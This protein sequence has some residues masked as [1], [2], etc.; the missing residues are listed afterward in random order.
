MSGAAGAMRKVAEI[1]EL[2]EARGKRVGIGEEKILLVRDGGAVRAYAA[3]CPHAGAPLDEGAVCGGRIV[4]PWHKGA[5]RVSDGALLEP[6]ALDGLSRYPVRVDESGAVLVSPGKIPPER[7]R[8]APDARAMVVVGAGAAGA[9]AA[10]ALR[11]F[12]FGG[13]VVLVGREPG[14]PYDR[15]SLSKFVVS[16]EMAPGEVPP[17]LPPGFF[18]ERRIERIEAEAVRLDAP[19]RR[20]HLNDGRALPYDAALIATGGVPKRLGVPGADLPGVF[21]L[22]D[23]PDAAA[24]LAAAPEGARAVVLGAGFI[25]LEAAS[26]LRKRKV[27]V[28][29]VSPETAPFGKQFGPRLGAVFKGL[30]EAN[31][32]AFRPGAQASRLE[33]ADRVEAVVLEDGTR[34]QADLVLAGVGV[35]PATGFVQGLALAEDGGIPVDAGMRAADGLYA[36]GDVALFPLPGGGKPTRIEHWRVAQQHARVAARNMLGGGGR[37]DG[38]PYFWTYHFGKRFDYL[39]HATEWDDVVVEGDTA[40]HAFVAFLVKEG[41]V[42]GVL[43]CQRERETAALSEGMRAPLP[44]DEAL[45]TVRAA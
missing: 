39:G 23:R 37:Y 3:T 40:E 18:E 27:D 38:V 34:L 11:E 20:V 15:T 26:A 28:T 19:A 41:R 10:A 6:P 43:G 32:V 17:L 5:F 12:G 42:V 45:R 16:G 1:G 31:G 33:G 35:R 13:R 22:R 29:V 9:A 4:C 7:P 44:L 36:A 24:I 21:V 8:E 14:L 2:A 30:H 25:G